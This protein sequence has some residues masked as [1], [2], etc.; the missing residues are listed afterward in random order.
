MHLRESAGQVSADISVPSTEINVLLVCLF[1][2]LDEIAALSA[3][4]IPTNI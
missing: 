1:V 3:L 4:C 2:F